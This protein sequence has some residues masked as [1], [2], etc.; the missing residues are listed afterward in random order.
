MQSKFL[1]GDIN[2]EVNFIITYSS[3]YL[4]VYNNVK[5]SDLNIESVKLQQISL[6][7]FVKENQIEYV[8]II[9]IDVEGYEPFVLDGCINT[10]KKFKPIL[11]IEITPL[12]FKNVGRPFKEILNYIKNH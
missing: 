5:G 12:W 8:N 10:I 11:Y 2:K 6:D 9:K 3:S 4:K 7:S 1:F